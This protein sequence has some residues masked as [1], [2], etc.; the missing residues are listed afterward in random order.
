MPAPCQRLDFPID[1]AYKRRHVKALIRLSRA[2][3]QYPECLA[4]DD[5]AMEAYP[6]AGGSYGDV[7]KG[8]LNGQQIALKVLK[9]YVD[10]DIVKLL[11]VMLYPFCPAFG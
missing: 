4:L 7:Y 1:P 5:V 2:S 10:Q 6:V 9:V 11:K 8:H 3:G